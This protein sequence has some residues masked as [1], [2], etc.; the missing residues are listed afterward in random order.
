[1]IAPVISVIIP[2][3]NHSRYLDQRLDSILK[4]TYQNF[5]IIIL[6]DCSTDNSCEVIEKYRN[7]PKVSSIVYNESNSGSTFK[8]WDKG[9]ALAKGDYIWIAESDDFCDYRFLEISV[10]QMI[11]NPA[12]VLV[13]CSSQ[14]V[15]SDG[16]VINPILPDR[17][18]AINIKNFIRDYMCFTN[19]IS[20]AGSAIFKKDILFKI[21]EE[22]KEYKAAGDKMFWIQIAEH[23]KVVYID[24]PL[25]YFRQHLIKVSPGKMR[26]G[27]TLREEFQIY[28]YLCKA[29]HIKGFIKK[30]LVKNHFCYYAYNNTFDSLDIQSEAIKTWKNKFFKSQVCV[31]IIFMINSYI[32]RFLHLKNRLLDSIYI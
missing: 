24:S 26:N 28:K 9:F 11:S 18:K 29:G 12:N 4:Q 5:E 14:F 7:N 25:N 27:T 15:D 21:T 22:Y 6:D 1:M 8:Q 3:Y 31:T 17:K 16:L 2:N 19:S 32:H 20:N 10:K 23:G 30:F 13:Y